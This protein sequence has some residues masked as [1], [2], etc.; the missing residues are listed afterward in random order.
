MLFSHIPGQNQSKSYL[1][2]L[3]QADRVPHAMLLTGPKGNAKLMFALALSVSLMCQE[4]EGLGSCGTCTDC[5]KAKK[6]IHPDIHFSFPVC[7][8]EGKKRDETTSTQFLGQWRS[9]I[10][11]TPWGGLENW[12][13][14]IK[15]AN[16]TLNINV[17]E[18]N[19]IIKN[20]SLR[21]YEGRYKIQIIW[22]SEFLG[23][24]G[25]R[26][27]KLIEEPTPDTIIIL[28]ADKQDMILNTVISRCQ[29]IKIPP[30]S[31]DA[32]QTFLQEKY[33]G[34]SS[35]EETIRLAS[36]DLRLAIELA[37]GDQKSWDQVLLQLLRC[38]YSGKFS[39]MFE[40]VAEL[41]S[42]G[43]DEIQAFCFYTIHFLKEYMKAYYTGSFDNIRLADK[44]R[45]TAS[46]MMNVIDPE[47]ALKITQLMERNLVEL[48]RNANSK[49]VWS[50]T[51]MEV[52]QILK[53]KKIA[54]NI[55]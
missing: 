25:N 20:L 14:H 39:E 24:E 37:E 15:S 31:D 13:M 26:L 48:Q 28:I 42:L 29:I 21:K 52:E 35:I 19:Q 36:G 6:Y 7:S 34:L 22:Q 2:K 12:L 8:I 4:E 50:A 11:S 51:M 40:L 9:F 55:A 46:R 47:M 10:Q 16:K 53:Q 30:F 3:V 5:I 17:T 33:S 18:C 38:T 43:K 49:I 41:T 1:E 27:L 54:R 44:E 23:K 45:Q 32:I